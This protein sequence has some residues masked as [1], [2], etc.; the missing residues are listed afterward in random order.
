MINF[1]G[2]HR[3]I[4]NFKNHYTF[5]IAVFTYLIINFNDK[6]P[7]WGLMDD[8]TSIR[9]SKQFSSKPFF[10]TIEWVA[11]NN[12]H[13]MF[14]PFFVLQQYFQY[15]FYDFNNPFPTYALNIFTVIFGIFLFTLVFIDKNDLYIFY[16]LL[17]LWPYTYDWFIMPTLNEKFGL[18]FLSLSLLLK[19]RGISAYLKLLLGIFA[20]LIK[21]NIVIF[22]PIVI[23]IE[24]T[25]NE[26]F[27]ATT[28]MLCG[29]IV[30][31]FFFFYYPD[32]YYNTG[33]IETFQLINFFT[34]QNLVVE[35]IV[36]FIIIDILFLNNDTNK[37][38]FLFS[39][40]ISIFLSFI[41][42]NLRNS[43]FAYLGT[44]LIFPI[45]IYLIS[46]INRLNLNK[47]KY[48][49]L[50]VSLITSNLLFLTPRL[51]RWN[52]IGSIVSIKSENKSVYFCGEGRFMLNVWDIE[53]NNTK[54]SFFSNFTDIV[55]SESIWMNSFSDNFKYIEYVESKNVSY[56]V[57]PYCDES[58]IFYSS[59]IGCN[60]DIL[61]KKEIIYIDSLDCST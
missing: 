8:A 11:Q 36:I 15:I 59:I 49:F 6:S 61:Y 10:T 4:K 58:L 44:I 52:D 47:I 60:F 9:L 34:I 24:K 35:V 19:S 40:L 57:D 22:L 33:L 28:G 53:A 17:L 14:R 7:F 18:I 31:T 30:Q 39:L 46:L 55:L 29:L 37:R 48:I 26:K 13:G 1:K 27:Y 45:S 41:I 12:S 2:S 43:S 56:I 23:Y 51:E 50:I 5:S 38:Y 20:L 3:M 21:L 16:A 25:K 54:N 32:S 42:L